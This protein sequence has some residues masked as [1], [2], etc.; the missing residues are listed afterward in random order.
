[1]ATK[2]AGI[3]KDT[4]CYKDVYT[5]EE[6]N[7]LLEDKS[8]TGH[9]HDD[10]Y[11]PRQDVLS[12]LAAKLNAENIKVVTAT[13]TTDSTGGGLTTI[14]YPDSSFNQYNTFIL[15]AAVYYNQQYQYGANVLRVSTNASGIS[16]ALNS[17]PANVSRTIKAV[18]YKHAAM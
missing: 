17:A 18:L 9:T 1:M 12:M 4:K 8:D 2:T 15:S 16:V 10:R 3:C 7:N 11:Y 14:S 5:E 13:V 6:I